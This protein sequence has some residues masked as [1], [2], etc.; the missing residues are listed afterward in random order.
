MRQVEEAHQLAGNLL[1]DVWLD[2]DGDVVFWNHEE[3]SWYYL[4]PWMGGV[5]PCRL[6]GV[7]GPF[8]RL[9]KGPR[10]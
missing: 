4:M 9:R 3:K 7:E 1:R 5:T 8:L 2:K 10:P 6:D